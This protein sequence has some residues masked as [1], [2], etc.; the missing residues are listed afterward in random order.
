MPEKLSRLAVFVAVMAAPLAAQDAS[1]RYELRFPNAVHHEAEI[2]AT[3]S[4]VRGRV[5][6]V[7][8]SRSSPGRYAL[9]EFAKNIYNI[10]ATD[11]AGKRLTVTRPTPYQWNVETNAGSTVVFEYTLFGDRADGTYNGID[12]THAHL[13]GPAT[14]A[15]ARGFEKSP[16]SVKIDVPQGSDWTAATQLA[17]GADGV[18]MAP[19]LDALMDA[20]LDIGPHVLREWTSDGS[21]FRLALHSQAPDDAVARFQK[22]C[23]AVVL[24]EEGVFGAFPKYDTGTYTLLFQHSGIR[25]LEFT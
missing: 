21:R 12:L 9:H 24:E 14:F 17:A 5:L 8:M 2:R 15:W 7:V 3:F 16:V 19:N 1:V 13:N 25:S 23:E 11:G 22:M 6:E 4:G 18:L 10:R 20:P